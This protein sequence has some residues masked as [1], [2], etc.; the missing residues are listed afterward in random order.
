MRLIQCCFEFDAG[1]VSERRLFFTEQ[2]AAQFGCSSSRRFRDLH[3][4]ALT[5]SSDLV[6]GKIQPKR[7]AVRPVVDRD[8]N[9]I[10]AA[11][12]DNALAGLVSFRRQHNRRSHTQSIPWERKGPVSFHERQE[13]P[14]AKPR[15]MVRDHQ[16]EQRFPRF[17]NV[18]RRAGA[19]ALCQPVGLRFRFQI[20]PHGQTPKMV[21]IAGSRLI[22]VHE[23]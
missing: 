10:G 16:V 2:D 15:L 1:F 7:I 14:T 11:G 9:G 12:T 18:G 5:L 4:R 8:L 6:S 22:P 13:N 23:L 20:Q 19:T 17:L 3:C 21:L